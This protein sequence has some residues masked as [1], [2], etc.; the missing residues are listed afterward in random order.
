MC[1]TLQCATRVG[2][3]WPFHFLYSCI[4]VF[5]KSI[6]HWNESYLY[7]AINCAFMR[8]HNS[9]SRNVKNINVCKNL[10]KWMVSWVY[11]SCLFAELYS[12]YSVHISTDFTVYMKF[13]M[14]SLRVKNIKYGSLT[15]TL[16]LLE[17]HKECRALLINNCQ[18]SFWVTSGSRACP[19]PYFI[20]P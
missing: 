6:I 19:Y 9:E 2:K 1:Y 14:Q 10:K 7:G 17:G 3:D 5:I 11:I 12:F 18:W 4:I 16:A 8:K 15:F 20:L 13:W